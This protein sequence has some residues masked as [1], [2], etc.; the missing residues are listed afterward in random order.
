MPDGW[1]T[2]VGLVEAVPACKIDGA[3]TA[4]G[5]ERSSW[6][7][8]ALLGPLGASVAGRIALPDWLPADEVPQAVGDQLSKLPVRRELTPVINTGYQLVALVLNLVLTLLKHFAQK[9]V[10]L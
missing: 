9:M 5:N 1:L 2:W 10:L 3:A 7:I 6:F 4:G 8:A